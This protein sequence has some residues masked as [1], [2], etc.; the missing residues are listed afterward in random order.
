[1]S[2][3]LDHDAASATEAPTVAGERAERVAAARAWLGELFGPL[4]ELG[5]SVRIA[6]DAADGWDELVPFFPGAEP[7]V[8]AEWDALLDWLAHAIVGTSDK[9]EANVF[10]VPYLH[11][12]RV[13]RRNGGAV[14]RCH[15]HADLDGPPL[16]DYRPRALGAMVV[17]SGSHNADGSPRTHCYV[18]L[19]EEVTPEV[20]TA[21]CRAFGQ[22]LAGPSHDLTK[23]A[24]ADY[25][26][27]PGTINHKHGARSAVRWITP[28][29]DPSVRTWTP[30]A[31][32]RLLGLGWPIRLP[33]DTAE[34]GGEVTGTHAATAVSPSSA[35]GELAARFAGRLAK[36]AEAPE[37]TRN[38]LLFWVAK[39]LG[40]YNAPAEFD[41]E[42]TA[43]ARETGLDAREIAATIA[44]GRNHGALHRADVLAGG[45]TWTAA[46]AN[47][48]P[49]EGAAPDLRREVSQ[50][51]E[52]IARR[53]LA[54]REAERIVA[55][56]EAQEN[57]LPDMEVSGAALFGLPD[58]IPL[59][60]TAEAPVSASGQAWMIVGED[61]T[62]KTSD[63]QQY[64][65]ARLN[66]DGWGG[67]MWGRPVA[68]LPEDES[69]YYLAMDRPRQALEAATRGLDQRRHG[70]ALRERLTF[71]QGP[72]PY[73]LWGA[74][75]A[76]WL[77][78]KV[79]QRRVG[80]LVLDSRKDAG[81]ATNPDSL[82]GINRLVQALCARGVEVLILHHPNQSSRAGRDPQLADVYGW[83]EVYSGLGSVV[84]LE[85]RAGETQLEVHHLK[86]IRARLEPFIIERD[87]AEGRS[88][89]VAGEHVVLDLS[90]LS[91]SQRGKWALIEPVL[92]ARPDGANPAELAVALGMQ[93]TSNL[94]KALAPL[95]R[96]GRL[97]HNGRHGHESRWLPGRAE[98]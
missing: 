74:A 65:K 92:T 54:E 53:R 73:P 25:L 26:R 62:G 29:G 50:M 23:I 30:E 37:G 14:S 55:E 51:A 87:H 35:G 42:L 68:P 13:R 63:A 16:D 7:G 44:S 22:W 58:V 59:F 9:H 76:E 98:S 96:Q 41:A 49:T 38:G 85:G 83:R 6:L 67:E 24:D 64:V 77:L 2:E 32:A 18:R 81:D 11:G 28:P 69:V 12:R 8:P 88:R 60:G 36:L 56:L 20:H 33:E 89:V 71:W 66:L 4:G 46:D 93:S 52:R 84:F 95:A 5:G 79:A 17:A 47:G 94:A 61:G 75:G 91:E 80:L 21:L 40:A 97:H 15:L 90:R 70:A 10:A 34:T 43:V 19:T 48:A 27:P 86:P 3:I 82:S 31:L 57:P 1:M 78:E 39:L 72:T 45:E